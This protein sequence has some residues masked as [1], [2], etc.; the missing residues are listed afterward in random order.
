MCKCGTTLYPEILKLLKNM[1]GSTRVPLPVLLFSLFFLLAT[2]SEVTIS[3]PG[4]LDLLDIMD[5]NVSIC[6]SIPGI[7]TLE[8]DVTVVLQVNTSLTG[9]IC[10]NF[11]KALLTSGTNF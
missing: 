2:D 11:W 10:A 9:K 4:G 6:A 5:L 8:V 7:T 1:H 3:A